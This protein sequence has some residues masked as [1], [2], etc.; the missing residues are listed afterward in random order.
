MNPAPENPAFTRPK[1]DKVIRSAATVPLK[2]SAPLSNGRTLHQSYKPQPFRVPL[3]VPSHAKPPS[4]DQRSVPSPATPL[5]E[6]EPLALKSNSTTKTARGKIIQA[7]SNKNSK[8]VVLCY[9]LI[10]ILSPGPIP[11]NKTWTWITCIDTSQK[12]T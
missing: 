9:Y 4:V 10:L 6:Q 7:A 2:A 12:E 11:Y 8:R 3:S 1:S 5:Q